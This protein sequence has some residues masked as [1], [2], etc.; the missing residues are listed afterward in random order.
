MG[1]VDGTDNPALHSDDFN[2]LVWIESGPEWAVGGTILV[3][4]RIAMHLDT[5]DKLGRTDKE[6]VIGRTLAN[7]APLG[8]T[9]EADAPDF[10]QRTKSGLTVIPQFAHIRRASASNPDERFFRRPFNYE[11]GVS[12]QGVPDV[13]MLWTAYMRN[14]KQYVPVQSRLA[15]FDLLNQ[16]TTPI[17][18]SVFA[19]AGGVKPGEIIAE[20]L[21]S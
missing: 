9:D 11:V 4:R 8:K 18:S 2:R 13:G 16:W 7:G 19:I 17:G 12:A 6:S 1:Q 15:S 20:R 10:D 5:W 21:F 3:L 14:M